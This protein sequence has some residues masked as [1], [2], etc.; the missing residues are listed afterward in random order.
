VVSGHPEKRAA[1]QGKAFEK[2]EPM[3]KASRTGNSIS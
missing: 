2:K 1:R 3:V